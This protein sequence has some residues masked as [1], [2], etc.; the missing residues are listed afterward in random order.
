MR[1]IVRVLACEQGLQLVDCTLVRSN[2]ADNR[3]CDFGGLDIAQ[4]CYGP[5]E[6]SRQTCLK[7]G[8][9][10]G[11]KLSFSYKKTVGKLVILKCRTRKYLQALNGELL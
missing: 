11:Y 5:S 8:L 2:D 3:C 7:C 1:T 10:T 9:L 4:T 6:E